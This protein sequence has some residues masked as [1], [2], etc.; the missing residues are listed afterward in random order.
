MFLYNTFT[1]WAS[2]L[3]VS[4]EKKQTARFAIFLRGHRIHLADSKEDAEKFI[5]DSFEFID[6]S[7]VGGRGFGTHQN[8]SKRKRWIGYRS[9]VKI[10][11][12]KR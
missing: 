8:A 6:S 4:K 2:S 7:H 10:M 11:E 9:Q 12:L 3:W 1:R 5:R